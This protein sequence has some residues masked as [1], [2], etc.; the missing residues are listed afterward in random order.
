M[1]KNKKIKFKPFEG[2]TVNTQYER[3]DVEQYFCVGGNLG[4]KTKVTRYEEKETRKKTSAYRIVYSSARLK[5]M[6]DTTVK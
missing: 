3:Y 4:D 2:K 5:H 1:F 6:N